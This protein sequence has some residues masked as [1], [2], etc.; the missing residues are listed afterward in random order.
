MFK[1]GKSKLL[2][3]SR[4]IVVIFSDISRY[5]FPENLAI[6]IYYF[7]GVFSKKKKK[8]RGKWKKYY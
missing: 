7:A 6:N 1:N 2:E 3:C 8:M 4:L 5:L